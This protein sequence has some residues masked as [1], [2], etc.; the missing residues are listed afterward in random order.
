MK[1]ERQTFERFAV[2]RILNSDFRILNL[3]L[4]VHPTRYAR[5]QCQ[6]RQQPIFFNSEFR[7]QNSEFV[8]DR[9][10][11]SLRSGTMSAS[12]AANLLQF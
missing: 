4:T 1:D 8:F 10:S 11:H 12:A 2:W 9:S 7:F 5:G 6:H 3:Y